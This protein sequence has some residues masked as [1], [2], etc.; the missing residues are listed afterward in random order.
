MS[1]LELYKFVQDK[2][3]DWRGETLMLWLD[4]DDL[5]AFSELEGDVIVDDGGYEVTLL[6]GG[7][8]CI[9]LNDVC[10]IHEI[11]PTNILEKE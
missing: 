7:M 9:E 4:G 3:I 10:E 6:Q 8:I 1:E 11:E 2:E 5:E